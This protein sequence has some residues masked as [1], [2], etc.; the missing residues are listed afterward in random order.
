MLTLC[1][2]LHAQ[3]DGAIRR[4]VIKVFATSNQLD[5]SNPWKRGGS[6]QSTGSGIWLGEK[7]I[8]TN[9]HVVNYA[10]QISVQPYESADRIPAEVVILAGDGLG[11][12]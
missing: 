3:D 11:H 9:D 5:L 8:L 12:H 2:N 1:G 4:S 6:K 10:T 7:R